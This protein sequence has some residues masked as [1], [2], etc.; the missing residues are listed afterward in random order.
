MK[1][2]LSLAGTL[3][4]IIALIIVPMVVLGDTTVHS[5]TGQAWANMPNP[6]DENKNP[7]NCHP[8]YI[9]DN[10]ND[11]GKDGVGCGQGLGW[12]N[13]NNVTLNSLNGQFSGTA[14]SQYGGT[15]NFGIDS[16]SAPQAPLLSARVD[17]ACLK[18]SAECPVTGWIKFTQASDGWDGWVKMS[19]ATTTKGSYGV[20]FLAPDSSGIREMSGYAWGSH[21]AGWID[22][23]RV[24]VK[25]ET[26]ILG[27]TDPKATNY[28]SSATKDNGSCEYQITKK[29]PYCGNPLA[30]PPTGANYMSPEKVAARLKQL[31]AQNDGYVWEM[32]RDDSTC[33]I[34]PEGTS[35]D[36]VKDSCVKEVKKQEKYCADPTA[37]NYKNTNDV[38]IRLKQLQAQNDGFVWSMVKD[39]SICK[40]PP[41]PDWCANIPGWKTTTLPTEG[42]PNVKWNEVDNNC[43]PSA[44]KLADRSNYY[45]ASTITVMGTSIP[46]QTNNDLCSVI[47]CQWPPLDPNG[48]C[49]EVKNAQGYCSSGPVKPGSPTET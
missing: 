3:F 47:E 44:C 46:V 41:S 27:C 4:A 42:S 37:T 18:T 15:V 20:K 43:I 45:A 35:F 34:C 24:S 13:L 12:I 8:K 32:V 48:K 23:S 6:N 25:I 16:S 22:F 38:A 28:D 29:Q 9:D 33:L 30:T 40:Y 31:Q 1:F 5:V 19:G 2:H 10:S 14:Q 49:C 39:N 17:P 26:D 11:Y 36:I 7:D 21:V